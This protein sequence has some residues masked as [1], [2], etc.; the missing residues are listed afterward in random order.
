MKKHRLLYIIMLLI[1]SFTLIGCGNEEPTTEI[2]QEKPSATIDYSDSKENAKKEINNYID[3]NKA[4][5]SPSSLTA[6]TTLKTTTF[7]Y[8]DS[9]TSF[10]TITNHKKLCIN[11]IDILLTTDQYN[12]DLA[13]IDLKYDMLVEEEQD[14]LEEIK[15]AGYYTESKISWQNEMAEIDNKLQGELTPAQ[16]EQLQSEKAR[17][18]LLWENRNKYNASLDEIDSLNSQRNI[19]KNSLLQEYKIDIMAIDINIQW[20]EDALN[21][22]VEEEK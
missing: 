11:K 7:A 5:L 13:N 2:P 3:E 9:S 14:K 19:D 6:I 1:C 18:E 17:L 15:T 22:N 12:L 8:I 10:A 16:K 4:I 21:L 20:L